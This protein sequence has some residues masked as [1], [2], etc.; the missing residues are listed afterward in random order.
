MSNKKHEVKISRRSQDA[1]IEK[2]LHQLHVDLKRCLLT[3]IILFFTKIRPHYALE[4]QRKMSR[5]GEGRFNIE[6][7]VVYDNLKKLER[8]GLLGSFLVKS[9]IGAKRKYY[10]LTKFGER[11][12][13]EIVFKA[14]HPL[15]FMFSTIMENRIEELGIKRR[16]SRKE[17]NRIQKLINEE[18]DK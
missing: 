3:Y 11:F 1:I 6:K 13:E 2:Q 7:N 18:I 16:S 12:F 5:I 8:K 14:L 15:T 10:Y 17:M 9:N 4:V